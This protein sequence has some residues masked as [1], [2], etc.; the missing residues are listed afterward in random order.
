MAYSEKIREAAFGIYCTG[1]S[2]DTIAE[3]LKKQFPEKCEKLSRHTVMKWEGRYNWEARAEVILRKTREKVDAKRIDRRSEMIVDM[4]ALEEL[5]LK[6][7]RKVEP[8]SL[9]GVV[10]GLL[11]V[12]KRVLQLR[13]EWDKRGNVKGEALEQVLQVVFEVLAEDE[14]IGARLAERQDFILQK[15]EERLN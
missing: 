2:F 8:K 14:K 15:I 3:Q 5:L 4:E 6:K 1:V 7:T 11:A 12:N 13:G 9:E 10:N